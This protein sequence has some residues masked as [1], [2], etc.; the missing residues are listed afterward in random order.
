MSDDRLARMRNIVKRNSGARALVDSVWE[1]FES[2]VECV[3]I[4]N[5]GEP[6]GHRLTGLGETP[7]QIGDV[8][9]LITVRDSPRMEEAF[10]HE[11]LHANLV[12]LGYPTF[13]IDEWNDSEEWRIGG[14]ITN[15]ADHVAM[16][17]TYLALGYSPSQFTGPYV[18]SAREGQV[19]SEI[20]SLDLSAP[21]KYLNEISLCLRRW[22]VRHRAMRLGDV[23]GGRRRTR[24][25][26]PA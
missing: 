24:P 8:G 16:R 20:E 7:D 3:I 23:I 15:N 11:L 4:E 2:R 13:W 12:R 9:V 19:I 18:L 1:F 25:F 22:N 21:G 6:S 10:V 14:G 26:P 17:P 5:D